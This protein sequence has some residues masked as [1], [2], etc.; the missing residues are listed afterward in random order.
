MQ[1]ELVFLQY[2]FRKPEKATCYK[3]I[4]ICNTNIWSYTI[5]GRRKQTLVFRHCWMT[6]SLPITQTNKAPAVTVVQ[7]TGSLLKA[8][9]HLDPALLRSLLGTILFAVSDHGPSHIH[10]RHAMLAHCKFRTTSAA[11]RNRKM[12]SQKNWQKSKSYWLS[13]KPKLGTNAAVQNSLPI[14]CHHQVAVV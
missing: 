8:E 9:N 11:W 10:N 7:K 3:N 2:A 5:C 13:Q 12:E 6:D 14:P 4:T 1:L